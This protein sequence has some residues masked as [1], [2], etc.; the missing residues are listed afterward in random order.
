M[1]QYLFI[2]SSISSSDPAT[3]PIT[4][5][6]TTTANIEIATPII[7]PKIIKSSYAYPPNI[8]LLL[9]NFFMISQKLIC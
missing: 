3:A 1:Y 8:L 6:I 4:E 5:M 9:Y 7:G 2:Y